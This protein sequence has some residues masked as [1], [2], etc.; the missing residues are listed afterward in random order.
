M[1][2]GRA[3]P[4][5]PSVTLARGLPRQVVQKLTRMVGKNVKLYDMVLQFLRTLF[6]RTRN[7]HYCTLR[8]EL[9]MCLH[10]LD[11][12]DICSVDPCHKVAP[13]LALSHPGVLLRLSLLSLGLTPPTPGLPLPTRLTP[14][15]TAGPAPPLLTCLLHRLLWSGL[16][17][18]SPRAAHGRRRAPG[19]RCPCCPCAQHGCCAARVPRLL[20]VCCSTHRRSHQSGALFVFFIT[21]FSGTNPEDNLYLLVKCRSPGLKSTAS[22]AVR[23]APC[24]VPGW[25]TRTIGLLLRGS[26][27]AFRSPSCFL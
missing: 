25:V 17:A 15:H 20:G 26:Y 21:V 7:V 8:A 27:C 23:W 19:P 18:C 22:P 4:A 13:R 2:A 11:V 24:Q 14:K 16:A 9:L 12:G 1:G 10:D 6:L 3:R 5:W